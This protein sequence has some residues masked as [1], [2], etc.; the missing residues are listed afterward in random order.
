MNERRGRGSGRGTRRG[1]ANGGYG[2]GGTN[3]YG[4]AHTA[5]ATN[6]RGSCTSDLSPE[7]WKAITQIIND[8]RSSSQYEKLNGKTRGVQSGKTKPIKT[9]QNRN[10]ESGLDW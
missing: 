7:K 9:E 4:S 10:R 5:H 6:S 1:S 8:G 3:G 2:R